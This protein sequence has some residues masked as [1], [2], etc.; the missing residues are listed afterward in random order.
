[1]DVKNT[2]VDKFMK[3]PE[4]EIPDTLKMENDSSSETT[5]IP[6]EFTV[7][8][9]SN[10]EQQFPS[11]HDVNEEESKN[12]VYLDNDD[13]SRDFLMDRDLTKQYTIQL[14][15]YHMNM[16]L[17][18]PFLEFYLEGSN[19][20]YSFPEKMVD[21]QKLESAIEE[22]NN[23]QQGGMEITTEQRGDIEMGVKTT[24]IENNDINPFEQQIFELFNNVTGYSD[25][26]AE[27]AY[28]GFVEHNNNIYVLFENKEKVI[29]NDHTE[30]NNMWVILDEIMK[31]SVLN[32]TIQESVYNLFLEHT[33]LAHISSEGT[34][35]DIPVVVYPVDKV[36]NIYENIYYSSE[37]TDETYL[38]TIPMDNDEYGH[39]FLFTPTILPSNQDV[40]SIKRM[41]IFTQKAL[42][43]L[44]KP[45][46]ELFDKYPIIRFKEDDLTFWGISNYLLFTELL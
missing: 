14:V 44:T 12:Y 10:N 24:I 7:K 22:I 6:D 25:I 18:L 40:N 41:V 36:N 39:M 19:S 30:Q 15:M 4:D 9:T 28:K 11:V 34:N 3:S 26:I 20:S 31:Q 5:N 8:L 29:Q 21:N 27:N 23:T 17:D 32:A 43:M 45:T 2:I 35:I 33:K 13:L 1:M 42:Y 37:N 16:T 46:K 38:I